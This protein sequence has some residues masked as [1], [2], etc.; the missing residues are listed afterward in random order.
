MSAKPVPGILFR[1]EIEPLELLGS[2]QPLVDVKEAGTGARPPK[3]CRLLPNQ[4]SDFS[5]PKTTRCGARDE[6]KKNSGRELGVGGRRPSPS[7]ALSECR[8]MTHYRRANLCGEGEFC[9][10]PRRQSK[11]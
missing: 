9:Q 5:S 4:P 1:L 2:E 7:A 3:Q 10:G 6:S 8:S 11:W